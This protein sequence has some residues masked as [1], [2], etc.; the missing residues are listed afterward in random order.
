[1]GFVLAR[2]TKEWIQAALSFVYPEWCKLCDGMRAAPGHGF[3]CERCRGAVRRVQPPWC[4]RCGRPFQGAI[5]GTFVCSQCLDIRPVYTFARAA[6]VY[7]DTLLEAIHR[8][9]YNRALYIE[10][11]LAALLTEAA[12]NVVT[13]AEWDVIVPVPL[14]WKKKWHREFNQAERLARRLAKAT[15]V[16]IQP[17]LLRRKTHTPSQTKLTREERFE[18]MRGAFEVR[19][20][21]RPGLR[22]V[23]VD[24]VFT[25]GA[26][27]NAC[28]AA[29]LDAGA[30]SVCVWT[31]ARGG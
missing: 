1:V 23:V 15:G 27:T 12:R 17:R 18:N 24:D 29:L 6:A 3:V 31:V 14:H 20:R 16:P 4:E 7:Q 25:T 8:Y 26:T 19:G 5:S 30:G 11:F 22:V 21:V 28:A 2:A 10:P 9:K 13:P